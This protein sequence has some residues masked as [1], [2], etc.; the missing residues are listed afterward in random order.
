[1]KTLETTLTCHQGNLGLNVPDG[2]LPGFLIDAYN[3][4]T[5]GRPWCDAQPALRSI[6]M[7]RSVN[8]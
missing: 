4:V 3:R 7:A 1:M 8:S 6:A 5:T 2:V